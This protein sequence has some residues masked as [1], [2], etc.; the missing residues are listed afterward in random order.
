MFLV[1]GTRQLS[2]HGLP[3]HKQFEDESHSRVHEKH[4]SPAAQERDETV[5]GSE[6][7]ETDTEEE[8]TTEPEQ[9]SV[10]TRHGEEE[11]TRKR[12][13][14]GQ[15]S[16]RTVQEEGHEKRSPGQRGATRDTLQPEGRGTEEGPP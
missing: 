1:F 12:N 15:S 2:A 3:T 14:A 13:C 9:E 11:E 5:H 7:N 4:G 16:S 6:A 8:L 10:S